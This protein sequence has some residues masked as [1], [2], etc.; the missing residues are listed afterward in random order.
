MTRVLLAQ[1]KIC[2]TL[3]ASLAVRPQLR[4]TTCHKKFNFWQSTLL[5]WEVNHT[6]VSHSEDIQ[7]VCR[8]LLLSKWSSLN[9][10]IIAFNWLQFPDIALSRIDTVHCTHTRRKAY[11][12]YLNSA[13]VL[14][15]A[16]ILSLASYLLLSLLLPPASWSIQ[17][18]TFIEHLLFDVQKPCIESTFRT[19]IE[20]NYLR[21]SS[22]S[23][24][25][26]ADSQ[27]PVKENHFPKTE[28][29]IVK[30]LP[31]YDSLS[32]AE[33]ILLLLVPGVFV[34]P[35]WKWKTPKIRLALL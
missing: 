4:W 13:S 30:T 29:Y 18:H 23:G 10:H 31:L 35:S 16:W 14:N 28:V 27:L 6:S 26:E 11:Q 17:E 3:Q 32:V 22:E 8:H 19:C 33:Q 25:D 20:S 7:A 9:Y 24:N 34:F 1:F 5:H 21:T 15:S 2:Q 12:W